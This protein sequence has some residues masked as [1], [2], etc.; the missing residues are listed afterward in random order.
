[1]PWALMSDVP[2]I[3]Q[4]EFRERRLFVGH[5][6]AGVL[7]LVSNPGRIL[8]GQTPVRSPGAS[9]ARILQVGEVWRDPERRGLVVTGSKIDGTGA[10]QGWTIDELA[11]VARNPGRYGLKA[12][13]LSVGR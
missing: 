3:T 1:M 10:S 4:E 12:D 5:V 6:I 13:K 2:R 7:A 9:R 11:A 8:A